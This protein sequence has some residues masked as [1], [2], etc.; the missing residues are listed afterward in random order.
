VALEV[1]VVDD[2]SEAP[3]ETLAVEEENVRRIRHETPRGV[4]E[5]RNTGIAHARGE[6]VAFLDDDDVWAPAY[7]RTL[8]AAARA[9]GADFAYS[10][11]VE[12]D[13]R[14]EVMRIPL[15]PE[16]G[17]LTQLLLR[18]N[19]VPAAASNTFVRT[20]L[21]R[22][23]G[24]FDPALR[25]LEDWDLWIRLALSGR[26][27]MS[28]EPLVGHMVHS[29]SIQVGDPE[30]LLP[31]FEYVAAKHRAAARRHGSAPHGLAFSR[32]VARYKWRGGEKPAALRIL[33]RGVFKYGSARGLWRGLR[34]LVRGEVSRARDEGLTAPTYEPSWLALY[35]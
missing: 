6:W 5:A 8:L 35:R 3:H 23:L 27:A 4:A 10:G 13:H 24:G 33:I 32:Y 28:P 26:G 34:S 16:P 19:A 22:R 18:H 17:E 2:G 12:V 7:L 15:T 1:I 14:F 31:A 25:L 29:G 9:V 11:A 20:E 30:K 21:M